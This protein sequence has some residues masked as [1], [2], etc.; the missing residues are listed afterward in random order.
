M[1][2][3]SNPANSVTAYCQTCYCE[4]KILKSRVARGDGKYCSKACARIGRR[5]RTE[6]KCRT[7][8]KTFYTIPS[9]LSNGRGKYC[10]TNCQWL[11]PK[12]LQ[13]LSKAITT[14]FKSGHTPWNKGYTKETHPIVQLISE[15]VKLNNPAS[16]PE[17][18]RKLSE[19]HKGQHPWNFGKVCPQFQGKNNA[20]WKG[21]Y[22]PY[23]GPNWRSQRK[24]ARQRDGNRCRICGKT[25][26][27]NGRTLDVH[28]IIPFR[29]YGRNGYLAANNLNNLI[30]VCM[31]CHQKIEGSYEK[32]LVMQCR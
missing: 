5:T 30:T 27:L 24:L 7:C 3:K 19:S 26:L 17:V 22:E 32:N 18:R 11:D 20:R 25:R 29:L 13:K 12:Y 16:R 4:F 21:G 1:V 15:L 28:H 23:Y 6:H 10:S 14:K 2:R 8:G 9:R 31:V